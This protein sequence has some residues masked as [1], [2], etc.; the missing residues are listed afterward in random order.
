[1]KIKLVLFFAFVLLGSIG[2]KAFGVAV[3][4]SAKYKWIKGEKFILHVVKAQ[5]TWSS[6][7]RKYALLIGDLMN[8]NL[9]VIDLKAGQL[10]NIPAKSSLAADDKKTENTSQVKNSG[11]ENKTAIMYYV[12][13]GET[14][15]SISKKFGSSVEDV[16]KWNNL[17]DNIVHEG[18]QLIV[19]YVPSKA[20]IKQEKK[21]E[22]AEIMTENKTAKNE[23]GKNAEVKN[24]TAEESKPKDVPGS[25]KEEA[26][27]ETAKQEKNVEIKKAA[28]EESKPKDVL[29]VKTEEA[30]KET[31]KQE[32]ATEVKKAPAEESK[33]NDVL[34]I[35][36]EE[37]Q[38]E[39][40]KQEKTPEIKK[41]PVAESKPKDVLVVKKDPVTKETIKPEKK[42]D[43]PAPDAVEAKVEPFEKAPDL[44]DNPT[45][46]MIPVG[47][48]SSGKTIMQ[49]TEFGVCSWINDAE[50]NQNKYYG[51][52]RTAPIGTIV[53]VINKMND[54]YVF[55]KIV[56]VLPDTGENEK[57]IIKI[58]QAAVN[59]VG[60][61]DAHFQ[62]ELSYGVLQ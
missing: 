41:A 19:S 1:M 32:K 60:A 39:S 14:L 50:V 62:V 12:R 51:L 57:S 27:K 3:P 35:K 38:K 10:L 37:A 13:T 48:G 30:P 4:D 40:V 8:A 59:K 52:H 26:Q 24:D 9:G 46:S 53:K 45:R 33:P 16:K 36:K 11:T 18:Q 2:A 54:K 25:K 58:S 20:E 56:G 15:F 42:P 31:A 61:L 23:P 7:S 21:P 34:V 55:V 6:I 47:K 17:P 49:V 5:E 28:A 29:V 22:P 43:V 44:S